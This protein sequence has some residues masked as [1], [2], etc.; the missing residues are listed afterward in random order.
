MPLESGKSK[1]AFKRNV[2]AEV[3]AGKPI[4]QALA[5]AYSKKREGAKR[6]HKRAAHVVKHHVHGNNGGY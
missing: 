4:K 6:H 1:A 5:I 3:H 2:S